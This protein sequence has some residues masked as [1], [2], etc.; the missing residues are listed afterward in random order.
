MPE[1]QIAVRIDVDSVRDV[2]YLPQLFDLLERLDIRATFFL[3]T[4]PDKVAL[5]LLRYITHPRLYLKFLRSRPLR[6]GLQSFEGLV[7]TQNV[8]EA[9]PS[10][11]K[12]VS[13]KHEM[14]LHGYDHY[15]WMNTV[16]GVDDETVARW[17]SRGT[18]ALEAVTG[19]CARSFASPGFTVTDGMLR[20]IDSFCF[21]YSSDF[22]SSSPMSPFY[23]EI[24][25]KT[26]QVLQV[27]VSMDSIG[28][29]LGQ[30]IKKEDILPKIRA[31]IDVWHSMGLPFVLFIHP[32]YE[33]GCEARLFSSM[34]EEW[35]CDPHLTFLTLAQIA[36]QWKVRL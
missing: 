16:Q 29:L 7:R 1:N 17:I 10:V 31:S 8:E 30:G 33:V 24:G 27:P 21:D 22:K 35:A 9:Y 3:A 19:V 26:S 4:G 25:E 13:K 15:V 6:Y 18:E 5:N 14:G 28:E 11:L 34:L 20:A 12:S 36:Q 2:A 23:P 32:A